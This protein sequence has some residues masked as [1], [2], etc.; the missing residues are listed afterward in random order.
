[1]I[2][3][4]LNSTPEQFNGYFE[5]ARQKLITGISNGMRQGMTGLAQYIVSSK[6]Q[7]GV[8]HE[9]T[10]HLV[11]A[12]LNSVRVSVTEE[13]V[14]GSVAAMPPEMPN[15]GLWNEFG[16]NHPA[17]AGK[18]H[19]FVAPGGGL[20]FSKKVRAFS[21]APRPFM[22]TSLHEQEQQIMSTIRAAVTEVQL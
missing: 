10:G 20:V 7:G 4:K 17:V 21:I 15:E 9:R 13:A 19:V 1:M 12:V 18:L 22:N 2:N 3:F 11:K 16:T 6:L 5:Q 8:L 14:R